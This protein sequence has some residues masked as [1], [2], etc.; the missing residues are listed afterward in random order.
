VLKGIREDPMA[1]Q[2]LGKNVVIIKLTVFGVASALAGMA[3]AFYA[4]WLRLA[5]PGLYGFPFA[6]TLFAIVIFGGMA[7]LWGSIL[8]SVIVVLLEPIL[9][10]VVDLDAATASVVQLIV[11][12]ATLAVLMMLRPQGAIPEGSH[13]LR[14]IRFAFTGGERSFWTR[15]RRGPIDAR[16]EM[17][18]DEDWEPTFAGSTEGASIGL[19]VEQRHD[20]W[21]QA[22]VVLEARGISKRFGGVVAAEELDIDLRAGTITA[23]VGPNGA[24]KTTVFNLLTGFVPPDAGSVR[25]NG[26]E[27]V[28]L[29]ADRIARMGLVRS[30]QDVRLIGRI[31]CLANVMMAV[32]EQTGE[33]F[34][35]LYFGGRSA[36]RAETE[37][38]ERAMEWLTFVGMTDFADTP[39]SALSYGQS[40]LVSLARLLATEAPVLLLDEPASGIDTR[41]V[42]TTLQMVEAVRDHGRTVCIVE[43]NLHV[44][45]RLAAHTYFMDLGRIT[46]Q[47]SLDELTASPE[48]AEA[49]FGR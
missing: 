37:T 33:R 32:Q 35:Q 3:G 7:N 15:L 18:A 4:G 10:D 43:H 9:R 38:R 41:W 49:Y 28:G 40:K 45:S 21:E 6:L 30:F 14:R 17:I 22:P 11:Y 8:G 34:W 2:A 23:L 31:S 36:S 19:S 44:V 46:A 20:R 27:L 47:G 29:T 26:E 25:L 39:A 24:G 12:G 5:T 48:L 16:Q 1:T 13:P 42:E